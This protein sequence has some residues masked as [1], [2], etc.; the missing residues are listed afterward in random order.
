MVLDTSAMLQIMRDGEEYRPS[1][2]AVA[3]HLRQNASWQPG[4]PLACRYLL[5]C[6]TAGAP[7]HGRRGLPRSRVISQVHQDRR[8]MA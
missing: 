7:M 8:R 1:P 3:R 6:D 4:Y 5:F 2:A